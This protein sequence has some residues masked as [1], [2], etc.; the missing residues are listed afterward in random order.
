VRQVPK[1]RPVPLDSRD[2]PV[3]APPDNK[4]PLGLRDLQARLV[5]QR[6]LL[7]SSD[8]QDRQADLLVRREPQVLPVPRDRRDPPDPQVRRV[9][10]ELPAPS[11]QR[12][13]RE[14]PDQSV[15]PVPRDP[16]VPQAP[17][18]SRE[19]PDRQ[20]RKGRPDPLVDRKA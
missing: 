12:E 20:D 1:D 2:R 18:V 15:L 9:P 11:A 17:L 3:L 5:D 8:L 7:G 16:L 4:A 14:L 6:G 13:R 10:Q 19:S